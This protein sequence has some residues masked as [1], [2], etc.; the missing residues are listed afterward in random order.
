MKRPP[1]MHVVPKYVV[2]MKNSKFINTLL[3]EHYYVCPI[4]TLFS[5]AYI[6]NVQLNL[7]ITITIGT[8]QT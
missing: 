6:S 4:I 2:N 1:V 5:L 7:I 8:G 3:K